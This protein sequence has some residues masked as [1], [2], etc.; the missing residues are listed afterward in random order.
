[1]NTVEKTES[2]ADELIRVKAQL[3]AGIKAMQA[4]EARRRTRWKIMASVGVVVLIAIAIAIF[5][6]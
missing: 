4:E 2:E 6:Q 3:A 5:S 1:M